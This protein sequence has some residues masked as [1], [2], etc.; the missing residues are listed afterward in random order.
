MISVMYRGDF[1]SFR[2]VFGVMPGVCAYDD[3]DGPNAL[4]TPQ[5]LI[6]DGDL[7][8]TEGTVI[9][10]ISLFERE[11][12]RCTMDSD[13]TISCG[14]NGNQ[15]IITAHE[16]GHIL[17]YKLGMRPDGPWQMEPHA[18]FLAGWA[19]ARLRK[20][21]VPISTLPSG[22]TL[23]AFTGGIMEAFDNPETFDEA[24]QTMF[25]KGDTG[26]TTPS[27]GQP[28]IRAAMVRAGRESADLDVRAAFDKGRSLVGM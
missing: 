10:G 3:S 4:A 21:Q 11:R 2:D 14:K 19:Y 26:F 28:A 12:T 13:Q 7:A 20:G 17:Q 9:L 6:S 23:N 18:D 16:F 5:S 1:L 25:E 27:H 24:V 15:Y 22:E 8:G